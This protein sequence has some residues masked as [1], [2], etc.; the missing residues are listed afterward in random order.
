MMDVGAA[1]L[2]FGIVALTVV[3]VLFVQDVLRARQK[4][5][6]LDKRAEPVVEP[7][8]PH[9]PVEVT[10]PVEPVVEQKPVVVKKKPKPKIVGMVVRKGQRDALTLRWHQ[11]NHLPADLAD[12]DSPELRNA[13]SPYLQALPALGVAT[14][15]NSANLMEVSIDGSLVRAADGSGFRAFSMDER[16]ISENAIL[17]NSAIDTA[18]SLTA[19]WYLASVVVAQKHL[20]DINRS[21]KRIEG[22]LDAILVFLERQRTARIEAGINYINKALAGARENQFPAHTRT[23]LASLSRDLDEVFIDLRGELESCLG[24]L[25]KA[26]S[27]DIYKHAVE[28]TDTAEKCVKQALWC[29]DAKLACWYAASLFPGDDAGQAEELDLIERNYAEI[30]GQIHNAR[31]AVKRPA[32]EMKTR[33]PWR[34]ATIRSQRRKLLSGATDFKRRFAASVDEGLNRMGKAQNMLD[35]FKT[36]QRLLVEVRDSAIISIR[37]M[38]AA[39]PARQHDG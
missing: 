34:R 1:V 37:S 30:A 36:P 21:L 20:A 17:N 33:L 16:G 19:A 9:A 5:R 26:P 18:A 12:R 31:E 2:L 29:L 15:A 3:A 28:M 27:G 6:D 38:P 14:M 35:D 4:A 23:E 13:L 11:L 25:G 8:K 7:E 10:R 32:R 24:G 22:K 39:E